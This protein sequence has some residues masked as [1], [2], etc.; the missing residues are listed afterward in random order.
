MSDRPKALVT[1]GTRGIGKAIVL[2]LGRA[3]FDVAF[4]GR[5]LKEGEG[6]EHAPDG[7]FSVL[8]GS[9]ESTAQALAEIG[10]DGLSIRMDL[11]QY[12][13]SRPA[14]QRIAF[15]GP[16]RAQ[17]CED[18]ALICGQVDVVEHPMAA[19]RLAHTPDF[20]PRST[21][22][23]GHGAPPSRWGPGGSGSSPATRSLSRCWI[24]SCSRSGI[25]STKKSANAAHSSKTARRSAGASAR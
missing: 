23:A 3:G 6:R 16:V 20:D 8:P 10:A 13:E 24:H 17:Q 12:D 11:Q 9:L 15:A 5:T 19:E 18:R 22:L 4:T 21:G 7:G 1:G 2:E 25:R 14:R